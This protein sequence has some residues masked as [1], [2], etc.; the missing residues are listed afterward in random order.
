MA[1][2]M[3]IVI[4]HDAAGVRWQAGQHASE[5]NK[6]RED[7]QNIYKLLT[8]ELVGKNRKHLKEILGHKPLEVFMGGLLGVLIAYIFR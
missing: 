2:I 5:I 6:I 3:T 4:A 7:L 8:G 1:A